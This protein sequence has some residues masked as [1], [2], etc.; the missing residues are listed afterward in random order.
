MIADNVILHNIVLMMT[1]LDDSLSDRDTILFI[2]LFNNYICL[3][4]F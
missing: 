3:D 4:I 1:P 2:K